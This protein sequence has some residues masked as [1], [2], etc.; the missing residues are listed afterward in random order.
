[1]IGRPPVPIE[2]RFWKKV[3]IPSAKACWLW[4]GAKDDDGY[5]F[6]KRR[7][8][9]QYRAHRLSYEMHQGWISP[10]Y[11]V[12]HHC[13][14]PSCVNPNHLFA[15]S[16]ADNTRDMIAKNRQP[17]LCGEK[18]AMAKL[19]DAQVIQIR[20]DQRSHVDI[21]KDFPVSASQ[22]KHIQSGRCWKH[23]L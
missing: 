18:N 2:H 17:R 5:G 21:A 4:Q 10:G 14:N 6:I 12:C 9:V 15:G 20:R 8:G 7:D 11:F 19:T 23:L 22:I 16:H 3:L 1:M 13:D